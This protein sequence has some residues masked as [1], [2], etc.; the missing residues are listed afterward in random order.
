MKITNEIELIDLGI[1]TGKSLVLSDFHLGF[2]EAM[3]K[4]GVL[5][6]RF[7]YKDTVKRLDALFEEIEKRKIKL[8][9]IILNGDI[10]HEFGSISKQEW[11]E[12][13]QLI[14]YLSAKTK[15]VIIVKGNHDVILEPIIRRRNIK[16]VKGYLIGNVLVAHGDSVPEIPKEAKTVLIGHEH[17]AISLREGAKTEKYKCFLKAKYKGLTL[18]VQ[19]SF[20]LVVEGTD[21]LKERTLSPLLEK[22][23][24]IEVFVVDEKSREVLRFGKLKV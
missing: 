17:P 19:P 18:L 6:P 5:V 8:E 1:L 16:I 13:L 15:E 21:V 7:Q 2:E 11:K 20:N 22:A 3:N 4:R 14:D 23:K 12:V 24:N 10:K 9:K